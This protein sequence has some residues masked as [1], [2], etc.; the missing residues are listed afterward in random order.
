[1][2]AQI[3]LLLSI[4]TLFSAPPKPEELRAAALKSRMAIHRAS[5]ELNVHRKTKEEPEYDV[6]VRSWLD[7]GKF[8]TDVY[9]PSR[10]GNQGPYREVYALNDREH[11]VFSDIPENDERLPDITI[12][13]KSKYSPN[14]HNQGIDI[15]KLGISPV[16]SLIQAYHLQ[17]V[18]SRGDLFEEAIES[19]SLDG[20]AC[21]KVTF[22]TRDGLDWELWFCPDQGNS[23]IRSQMSEKSTN[24][25]WTVDSR[26]RPFGSPPI[27]FPVQLQYT[28]VEKG[29]VNR[30]E[31]TEITIHSINEPIDP[32]VFTVAGINPPAGTRA[33]I[34]PY[35]PSTG[36]IWSWDGKTLQPKPQPASQ[37]APVSPSDQPRR[38]SSNN[39]PLWIFL[40]SC[41]L[42]ATLLIVKRI[43][44]Q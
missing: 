14:K 19:S 34:Y 43:R 39:Y 13:E 3:S 5:V 18:L 44:S 32:A 6:K 20:L 25:Q 27:W 16:D 2:S 11:I 30:V 10:A 8:R 15:R 28:A 42:L 37:P 22:K 35:D 4:I 41:S 36:N 40:A 9:R 26:S 24:Y 12:I 29:V 33:M 7:Q 17:E 21:W 31:K 38:P 23:L 1:M